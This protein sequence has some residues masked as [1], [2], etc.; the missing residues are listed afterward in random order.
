ML[1]LP[2]LKNN[3]D[4]IKIADLM[5]PINFIFYEDLLVTHLHVDKVKIIH[6]SKALIF[7]PALLHYLS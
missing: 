3:S 5:T 4:D 1:D 7:K 6:R 2:D